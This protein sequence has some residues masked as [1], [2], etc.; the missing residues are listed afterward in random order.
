MGRKMKLTDKDKG[1][2]GDCNISPKEVAKRLGCSVGA[3]NYHRRMRS[4]I[5]RRK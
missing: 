5:W 4:G 3:V 1:L 2:A